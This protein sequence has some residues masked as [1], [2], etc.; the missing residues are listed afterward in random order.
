MVYKASIR[1]I[2]PDLIVFSLSPIVFFGVTIYLAVNLSIMDALFPLLISFLTCIL[3]LY[4]YHRTNV[5]LSFHKKG[6]KSNKFFT[7]GFNGFI[8]WR[9]IKCANSRA[10]RKCKYVE[11]IISPE[12]LNDREA[13]SQKPPI[14]FLESKVRIYTDALTISNTEITQMINQRKKTKGDRRNESNLLDFMDR[15]TDIEL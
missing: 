12:Y 10:I 7:L 13:S 2:W 5:E 6:M 11:I 14:F 15:L 8:E 1:Q 4:I 3:P 9:Y